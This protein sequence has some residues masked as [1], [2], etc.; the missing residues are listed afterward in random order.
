MAEAAVSGRSFCRHL[1]GSQQGASDSGSGKARPRTGDRSWL[2]RDFLP[3]PWRI[4]RP[5]IAGVAS[6]RPGGARRAAACRD[7]LGRCLGW[8]S[9]EA[10]CRPVVLLGD[11]LRVLRKVLTGCRTAGRCVLMPGLSS[12][13]KGVPN[14]KLTERSIEPAGV[15]PATALRPDCAAVH[16]GLATEPAQLSC[17]VFKQHLTSVLLL[18]M[19]RETSIGRRH[20][21]R[22]VTSLDAIPHLGSHFAPC[23]V[24]PLRARSILS[25]DS[26]APFLQCHWLPSR[27]KSGFPNGAAGR[28]VCLCKPPCGHPPRPKEKKS[29]RLLRN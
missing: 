16:T 2:L 21:A 20:F 12:V 9:S 28:G 13:L 18:H 19:L 5:Q 1:Q 6:R 3:R 27:E 26:A 23:R 10:G 7:Q 11:W 17:T 15:A 14:A 29:W 22:D 8:R 4:E 24:E 25:Q